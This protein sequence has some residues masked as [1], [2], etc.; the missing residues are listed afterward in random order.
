MTVSFPSYTG[1][2][3][4]DHLLRPGDLWASLS[5]FFVPSHLTG[6]Y[7]SVLVK[8][9]EGD[10]PRNVKRSEIGLV[11]DLRGVAKDEEEAKEKQEVEEDVSQHQLYLFYI[12][13]SF[14]AQNFIA[15]I[16]WMWKAPREKKDRPK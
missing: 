9:S 7:D 8:L 14:Y 15:C 5:G 12:F 1:E 3:N 13:K 10:D 11:V 6:K 2:D 4:Y 16:F